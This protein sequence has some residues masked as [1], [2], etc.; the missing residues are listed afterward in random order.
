MLELHHAVIERLAADAVAAGQLA[1]AAVVLDVA[2]FG[3]S[4]V[5]KKEFGGHQQFDREIVGFPLAP[6][7]WP[8]LKAEAEV[9]VHKKIDALMKHVMADAV[10]EAETL[11][12]L[13]MGR[14]YPPDAALTLP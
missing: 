3:V 7:A 12:D 10:G 6:G 14:N 9:P 2:V 8:G 1:E 4:E 13:I 11:A 5:M